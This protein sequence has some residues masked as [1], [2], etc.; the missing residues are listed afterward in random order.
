M[1]DLS[2]TNSCQPDTVVTVHHN[3]MMITEMLD[4]AGELTLRFPAFSDV[5]LF[6]AEMEDGSVAVAS[7]EVASLGFYD[8]VAVQWQGDIGLGLHAYEFGAAFG[9]EGHVWRDTPYSM[10]RAALG[11]GG[12]LVSL[13]SAEAAQGM[14]AL[15]YTFP[16]ETTSQSGMVE[17]TVEA[18]V[19]EANCETTVEAQ[20]LQVGLDRDLV[21]RDLS[22][23]MPTC[24]TVGDFVVLHGLVESLMVGDA[25]AG[26]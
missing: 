18:E 22:M 20:T 8:R 11:Q 12:F 7:A 5:A 21:V 1:V 19:T 16:T 25:A 14:R 23:T 15:V 2:L 24:D 17:L 6:M 4:G 9:A 10:D 3:G 13:G 26:S